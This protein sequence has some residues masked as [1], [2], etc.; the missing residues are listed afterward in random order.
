MNNYRRVISLILIVCMCFGLSACGKKQEENQTTEQQATPQDATSESLFDESVVVTPNPLPME[1]PTLG[2]EKIYVYSYDSVFGNRMDSEFRSRY[3]EFSDLVEYRDLNYQVTDPAYMDALKEATE[4][5]EKPSVFIV[6]DNQVKRFLEWE[7]A[8][9]IADCGLDTTLYTKEAYPYTVDFGTDADGN[10]KALTWQAT[11]G[12]MFYNTKIAEE[13]LGVSDASSVQAMVSDFDGFME[14]AAKM[15]EAGYYMTSSPEDLMQ[16]WLDMKQTPW[17]VDGTLTVD[18]VVTDYLEGAKEIY[19]NNYSMNQARGTAKWSN[20]M[21]NGKVFCFFGSSVWLSKNSVFVPKEQKY[22]VCAGP[23]V[24]HLGGAYIFIGKDCPNNE[25]LALLLYTMTCDEDAMY[26][27]CETDD[28]FPNNQAAVSRLIA[29]GVT[30][31]DVYL[32]GQAPLETF[33]VIAKQLDR[34]N[35]TEYDTEIEEYFLAVSHTYNTGN[36]STLED[37]IE[38]LRK[39]VEEGV[40]EVSGYE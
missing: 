32:N 17:V 40:D 9:P 31:G 3:P 13:V 1:L 26:D 18:T 25:L 23:F 7:Y 2:G 28:D 30:M 11:P 21:S 4:G 6:P 37:A 16:P 36:K 24:Y 14:V 22:R 38:S 19:A 20:N 15:K 8:A 35:A 5:R 10:L 29:D 39:R 34:S 27:L 33:D 12:V